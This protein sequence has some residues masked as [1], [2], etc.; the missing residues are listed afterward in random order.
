MFYLL[1]RWRSNGAAAPIEETNLL[2]WLIFAAIRRVF[3]IFATLL[4]RD[5][6]QGTREEYIFVH[7]LIFQFSIEVIACISLL[8]GMHFVI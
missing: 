4:G 6:T 5:Y 3:V 7:V 1:K 2:F 8:F